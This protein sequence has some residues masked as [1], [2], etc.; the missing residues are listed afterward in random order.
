M[1]LTQLEY[2]LEIKKQGSISKAAQ[3]LYIAQPSMST[4]IRDLEKE[5][6]FDLI[7]RSKRG[8]TFTSLGEQA[9]N[10]AQHILAEVEALRALDQVA[11]DHMSGR[12]FLS[13]VP[14][15]CE[16]FVLDLLIS[17]SE[18]SPELHIILDENDGDT[19]LHQVG[20][21]EADLGVIMICSN[22]E[23]RFQ[24]ELNHHDLEFETLY[25]DEICFLVGAQN[26]FFDE[27][28]VTM[29]DILQF[30]YVYYKES[31]SEEDRAL[32]AKHSDIAELTA[33]C[34]KDRESVKRYVA[35]SRAMTILP[36]RAAQ[37]NLYLRTGLLH[38]LSISDERWTCR[39][40]VTYR[41]DRALTREARFLINEMA[42]R[43][44][45]E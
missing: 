5:L 17:L 2:L 1:R 11:T 36:A 28:S 13:A 4:A 19:V 23:A 9:V 10:K 31:F 15:V 24:R 25:E 14:F 7:N 21:W 12:I 38:A 3:H 35:Q 18:S 39:I 20:R 32:F 26:P 8:V 37:D 43:L 33:I 34:M 16:H 30:P 42:R 44:T 22:E 27:Q 40:G 41:K 6:G 45:D 29:K